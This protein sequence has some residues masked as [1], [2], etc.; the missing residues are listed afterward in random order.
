VNTRKLTAAERA[1]YRAECTTVLGNISRLRHER[2]LTLNELGRIIDASKQCVGQMLRGKMTP[3]HQT[4]VRL[5]VALGVRSTVEF[6]QPL[7]EA[8]P[9]VKPKKKRAVTT[10]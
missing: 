8:A 10:K 6:Y 4:L 2:G 9:T 5:A 1:L 3:R 7:P